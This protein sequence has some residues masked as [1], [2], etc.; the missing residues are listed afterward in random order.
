MLHAADVIRI[1]GLTAHPEGGCFRETFR[2]TLRVEGARPASTAIYFLLRAGERARWHRVGTVELWHY[3]AGASLALDIVTDQ[4]IE[5][6]RLG[7]DITSGERPQA[8]IPA[9]RWQ[10]AQSLGEWTL[11]GCTVAPGFDF[12]D[13]EMAPE[14]WLPA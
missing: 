8:V 11:A 1:L 12:A 3:Y 5:R 13:F 4:G 10:T 2:D 9:R 14:G 7:P 6:L